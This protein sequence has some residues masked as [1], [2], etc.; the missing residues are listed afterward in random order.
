[1]CLEFS[2]R[3]TDIN[4]TIILI[5]LNFFGLAA[6]NSVIFSKLIFDS[7]FHLY[8]ELSVKYSTPM[9]L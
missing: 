7:G 9:T 3:M 6:S 5:F 4:L 1:M 2:F 8:V